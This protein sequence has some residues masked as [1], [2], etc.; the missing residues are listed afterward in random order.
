MH[1]PSNTQ[2]CV[3]ARPESASQPSRHLINSLISSCLAVDAVVTIGG[4]SSQQG[5]RVIAQLCTLCRRCRYDVKR[6]VHCRLQPDAA[7]GQG[8]HVSAGDVARVVL[9][10][11]V[12]NTKDQLLCTTCLINEACRSNNNAAAAPAGAKV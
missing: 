4:Q 6:P 1:L 7:D 5:T 9:K 2:G 11:R 8:C 10:Q 3:A 12:V